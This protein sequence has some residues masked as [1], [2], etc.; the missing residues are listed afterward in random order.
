MD[1]ILI[2]DD[3]AAIRLLLTRYLDEHGYR[4]TTAAD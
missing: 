3:D 2:V 1:H 4:V